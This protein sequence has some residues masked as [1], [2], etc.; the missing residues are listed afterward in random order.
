M[1]AHAEQMTVAICESAPT[2]DAVVCDMTYRRMARD[3]PFTRFP[4]VVPRL[5]LFGADPT[6]PLTNVSFYVDA[7]PPVPVMSQDIGGWFCIGV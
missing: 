4:Q 7:L 1:L 3:R 5:R 2:C 6:A